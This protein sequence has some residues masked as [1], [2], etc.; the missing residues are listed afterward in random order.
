ML[1]LLLDA[2]C[3]SRLGASGSH[4][5]A[6]PTKASTPTQG[7]SPDKQMHEDKEEP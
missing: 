7:R 4:C 6:K 5:L 1:G 2:Y 3:I